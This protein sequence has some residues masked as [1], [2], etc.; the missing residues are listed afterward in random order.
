MMVQ[1]YEEYIENKNNANKSDKV[2]I[3]RELWNKLITFVPMKVI[4]AIVIYIVALVV[5][6]CTKE[7]MSRHHP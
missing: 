2:L 5:Y 1:R 6:I 7:L 3:Y 4:I